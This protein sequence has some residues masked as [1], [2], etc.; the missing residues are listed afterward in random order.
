MKF[1]R[2]SLLVVLSLSLL[3]LSGCGEDR[4]IITGSTTTD[5]TTQ[6]VAPASEGE[7]LY[8]QNCA[9]SGCHAVPT[10]LARSSRT[11]AKFKAKNMQSPPYAK[12]TLTDAQLQLIVDYLLTQP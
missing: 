1:N 8:V 7:T 4:T 2:Y 3:A 9:T 5:G 10:D 12:A 11:V 6:P